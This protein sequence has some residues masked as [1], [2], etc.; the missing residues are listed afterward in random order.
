MRRSQRE[1]VG[2]EPPTTWS[3]ARP[4]LSRDWTAWDR[5]LSN[6]MQDAIV[7]FARTGDPSTQAVRFAPYRQDN[8]MRVNFADAIG[9]DKLFTKGMDF[10]ERTPATVPPRGRGGRGSPG[11]RER[12]R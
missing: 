3:L 1:P 4:E 8:E 12:T 10:L 11:V 5:E 6:D 2:P 9:D 7:A